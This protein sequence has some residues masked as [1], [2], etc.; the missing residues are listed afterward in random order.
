[1]LY[2][3]DILSEYAVAPG[4]GKP[5]TQSRNR[6]RRVKKK[7]EKEA[8]RLA[9]TSTPTCISLTNSHPLGTQSKFQR[10]RDGPA[11]D[12]AVNAFSEAGTSDAVTNIELD[13][14]EVVTSQGPSIERTGEVMMSTLRNKNKKKGYKQST[15]VP[16]PRKIVFVDSTAPPPS[17]VQNC[18][19]VATSNQVVV[20]APAR[21]VVPSEKQDQG[22]LPP[23]M[24]VTSVDVEESMWQQTKTSNKHKSRKAEWSI[25]ESCYNRSVAGVE[26]ASQNEPSVS[27]EGSVETLDLDWDLVEKRWEMFEE[28]NHPEQLKV[29]GSVGWKVR[30]I[31][32]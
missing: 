17:Q 6:R 2:L 20:D 24:F 9:A 19:A 10:D 15:A 3:F 27:N 18:V 23:H 30:H 14:V 12:V 16:L 26:V 32:I 29:G 1:M 7:H 8:G 21:L 31:S 11:D 13:A 5:S 25:Q 4:F 22:K 28:I